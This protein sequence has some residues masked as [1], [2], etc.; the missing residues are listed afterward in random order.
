M[1]FKIKIQ[2]ISQPLPIIKVNCQRYTSFDRK[3][4]IKDLDFRRGR[5]HEI[6]HL[7]AD[8][9]RLDSMKNIT[10]RKEKGESMIEIKNNNSNNSC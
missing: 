4:V 2:I 1:I 6:I 10:H 5:F 9:R 7:A 3:S 8:P